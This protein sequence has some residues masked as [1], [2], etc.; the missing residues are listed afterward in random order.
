M[1][2][3]QRVLPTYLHNINKD[4]GMKLLRYGW[5]S[6]IFGSTLQVEG[7]GFIFY[8]VSD[9]FIIAYSSLRQK[10]K[11]TESEACQVHGWNIAFN[12]DNLN[13]YRSD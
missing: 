5:R 4:A 6:P 3:W 10:A 8:S 1:R 2:L 13:R 11:D 7:G 9:S 12:L